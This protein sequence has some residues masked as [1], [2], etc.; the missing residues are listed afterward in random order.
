MLEVIE[1]IHLLRGKNLALHTLGL[2][3]FNIEINRLGLVKT[4]VRDGQNQTAIGG[5]CCR[6]RE[7]GTWTIASILSALF[8]LEVCLTHLNGLCG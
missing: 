5:L 2:I 1:V 6:G 4:H 7:H 8:L 3:A